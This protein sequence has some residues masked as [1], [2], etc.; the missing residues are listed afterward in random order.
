MKMYLL[1]LISHGERA[2]HNAFGATESPWAKEREG[3]DVREEETSPDIWHSRGPFQAA[4]ATR[5]TAGG[6]RTRSSATVATA[7]GTWS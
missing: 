6:T 3:H 4:C 1:P 5:V 2:R 7:W